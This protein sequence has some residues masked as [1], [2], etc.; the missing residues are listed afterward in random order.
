MSKDSDEFHKKLKEDNKLDKLIQLDKRKSILFEKELTLKEHRATVDLNH[1]L[2]N[3]DDLERA[4][5]INFGQ[6]SDENINSIVTSLDEYMQAAR[7]CM[8][9]VCDAFKGLIPFFRKNLLLVLADTGGG[10]STVVANIVWEAVRTKNPATGKRCRVLVLT[11]EEASEDFYARISCLRMKWAYIKH[12]EFTDEQ[13]KTFSEDIPKLAANGLTVIGDNYDG[14]SGLTSTF[15]GIEMIF[16]NLIRD[17]EFYDVIIIDYYQNVSSSKMDPKLG[18]YEC[19]ERFA[20]LLDKYKNTYPAPIVLM[21]Q[22]NKLKDDDDTTPYNIRIKGRKVI[23]DKATYTVEL[24]PNYKI[25]YTAWVVHKS[26]FTGTTGDKIETGFDKGRYVPWTSDLETKAS[27]ALIEQLEKK[28]AEKLPPGVI[29]E[30]KKP[31]DELINKGEQNGPQ[32]S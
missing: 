13:R 19:Q 1:L 32:D 31:N 21:A 18:P 7:N 25:C 30:D 2:K 17:Q 22:I 28:D 15:E 9:F 12:H 8:S 5:V 26:R 20:Q 27:K 11:N 14:V 6:M 3:T 29:I 10:K 24:R 16:E 23:C 4:K